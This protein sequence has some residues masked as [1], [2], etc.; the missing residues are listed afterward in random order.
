[1]SGYFYSC[2]I[3]KW[4]DMKNSIELEN[5]RLIMRAKFQKETLSYE[6][7]AEFNVFYTIGYMNSRLYTPMV[8]AYKN[9]WCY[10]Q[11]I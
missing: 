2:Y 4:A 9:G 10:A 1:M 7:K 11:Y 3:N 5:L 8:V 6:T